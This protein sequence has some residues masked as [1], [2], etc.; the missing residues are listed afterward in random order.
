MEPMMDLLV[1]MNKH[2]GDKTVLQPF[3]L[4]FPIYCDI[5]VYRLQDDEQNDRWIQNI[6]FPTMQKLKAQMFF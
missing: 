2:S 4:F 5:L 1:Y 6:G 3:P